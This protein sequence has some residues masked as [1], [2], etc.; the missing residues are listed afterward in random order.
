MDPSSGH[1]VLCGLNEL[2]YRTVEGLRRMGEQVVVITR[3]SEHR[4]TQAAHALGAALIVGSPREE[5]VL[6]AA[7]I[8]GASAL[9]L[10]EDDDI[11][12]LHAALA[13]QDLNPRLRIG[14]RLFDQELGQQVPR[15]FYDC[16]ILDPA[17]VAAPAFVSAALHQDRQQQLELAG[18]FLGVRRI[19]TKAP[20]VLLPLARTLSDGSAEIFPTDGGNVLCLVDHTPIRPWKDDHT[21]WEHKRL[22]GQTSPYDPPRISA[23]IMQETHTGRALA[24]WLRHPD[25]ACGRRLFMQGAYRGEPDPQEAQDATHST[26]HQ[27]WAQ[28]D[29]IA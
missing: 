7:G 4:F 23:P 8:T 13:A 28:A 15:L 12:N 11:G 17:T 10:T 19:S 3:S 29:A 21:S 5:S 27:R 14:L 16:C 26:H 25:L 22:R 9:L 2:G 20:G 1:V 6:R 24:L 18:R